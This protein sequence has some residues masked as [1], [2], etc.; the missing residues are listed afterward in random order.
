M[1]AALFCAFL[2]AGCTQQSPPAGT[3]AASS[4]SARPVPVLESRVN[5]LT[6]TLAP[7]AR[8]HLE[9]LLADYEAETTHQIAVLL[10]P[11]LGG[12]PIEAFSLRVAN[13]WALGRQGVDNGILVTL[14]M[15][16]RAVR[17]E[18]GYGMNRYI[19]NEAAAAIIDQRMLP[20]FRQGDFAGGL[21]A[22]LND[23]MNQGRAFVAPPR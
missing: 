14:S 17:I 2:L 4:A 8:Q 10:V 16:E 15:A 12:E 5:D 22:G 1:L 23:L 19:S 18:L 20:A 21:E 7:P 13:A 9:K 6:G 11:D 3:P